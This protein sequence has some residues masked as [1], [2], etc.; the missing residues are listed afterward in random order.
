MCRK[1]SLYHY[2]ALKCGECES[3]QDVYQNR[4]NNRVLCLKCINDKL[5]ESEDRKA[6]LTIIENNNEE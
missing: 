4:F 6:Q 1:D 3:M 5:R 2:D